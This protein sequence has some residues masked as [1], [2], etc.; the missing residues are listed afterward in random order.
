MEVMTAIL[1]AVSV[2]IGFIFA[3]R[4]EYNIANFSLLLAILLQ[5]FLLHEDE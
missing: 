2:M 1:M 4:G 3:A 5:N